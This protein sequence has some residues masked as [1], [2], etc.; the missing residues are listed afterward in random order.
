[1]HVTVGD[2]K[3]L[4]STVIGDTG[5]SHFQGFDYGQYWIII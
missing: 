3:L 1:M 2:F 4:A 5:N